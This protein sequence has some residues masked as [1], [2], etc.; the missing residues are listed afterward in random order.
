MEFIS[1][2]E[3]GSAASRI[4]FEIAAVSPLRRASNRRKVRTDSSRVAAG[5]GLGERRGGAILGGGLDA[6]EEAI[7]E[8]RVVDAVKDGVECDE[9]EGAYD[10]ARLWWV[11]VEE[12][13]DLRLSLL[14]MVAV[15]VGD[16]RPAEGGPCEVVGEGTEM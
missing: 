5:A 14:P 11:F 8:S 13:E 2:E 15:L 3:P 4:D 16:S 9:G 6:E 12:V 7:L 1:R 10:L